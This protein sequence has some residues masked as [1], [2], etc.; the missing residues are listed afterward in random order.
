MISSISNL[1]AGSP[2]PIMGSNTLNQA[3]QTKLEEIL[4][5]YD[6]SNMTV[7][8]MKAMNQAIISAR[9]Q[10]GKGM[11]NT[12]EE[13]GFDTQ[14]LME[15]AREQFGSATP[16]PPPGQSEQS[17]QSSGV[18]DEISQLLMTLIQEIQSGNVDQSDLQDFLDSL[19]SQSGNFSG[20]LIDTS[21]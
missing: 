10:P 19:V 11:I 21:A 14:A 17:E 16:P 5:K 6:P 2:S 15:T 1:V 20:N 7:E 12:L 4:A 13:G 8:D 3:D 9:I 18:N